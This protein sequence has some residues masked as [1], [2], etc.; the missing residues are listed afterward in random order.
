M[1]L[2]MAND[3]PLDIT[4]LQA[5]ERSALDLHIFS[6][7]LETLTQ[8]DFNIETFP[9]MPLLT[10]IMLSSSVPII[11]STGSYEGVSYVDGG[12]S[13]NFPLVSLLEHPSKPD[14]STVLC[15]HMTGPIPVYKIGAS[16][17]E[18]MTYITVNATMQMSCFHANHTMGQKTC[19]HYVYY[20]SSSI[21]SKTLWEKFLYCEDERRSLYDNGLEIAR[22]HLAKL[23][24]KEPLKEEVPSPC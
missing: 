24:A 3:I 8:V 22:A 16:M 13:N 10:A 14:P 1:P 2:F 18:L 5:R 9:N 20:E 21:W 17:M 12:L 4:F 6:T 19:K 11:F 23:L 15:I 7:N